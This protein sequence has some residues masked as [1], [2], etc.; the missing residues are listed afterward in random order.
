M[1]YNKRMRLQVCDELNADHLPL[2]HGLTSDF[3]SNLQGKNQPVN[4][5]FNRI[6]ALGNKLQLWEFQLH[7]DNPTH[8]SSHRMENP[9]YTE[10]HADIYVIQI[11]QH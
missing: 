5:M 7:W 1:L 11:I 9:T 6:K 2:Q 3:H 8:I 10:K 4:D